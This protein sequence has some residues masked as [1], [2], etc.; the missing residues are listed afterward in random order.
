MEE[1]GALLKNLTW[2]LSW[3]VRLEVILGSFHLFT[4]LNV[5]QK[6][7]QVMSCRLNIWNVH[8]WEK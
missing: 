8:P 6:K 1:A 2:N 3:G 7:K 4:G 5:N